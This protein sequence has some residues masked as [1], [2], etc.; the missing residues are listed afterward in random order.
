M[1]RFD[2]HPR[3]LS[4]L[5][6]KIANRELA[7]PDFQRSF[8]WDPNQTEMLIESIASGFPA[9]S[10]LFAK[11][12]PDFLAIREFEGAPEL[13]DE[14]PNE[15]V[16][17]GQQRLTSL[18]QA[19]TGSGE[20]EYFVAIQHLLDGDVEAAV[21]HESRKRAERKRLGD[22]EVQARDLLLPIPRLFEDNG[23]G[24]WRDQVLA[25][26][27]DGEELGTRLWDVHSQWLSNIQT[28]QFPVVTLSE[29]T[30]LE[31]ICN[32]FE[33][34]NNT[35]VRL[36]VFELLTARF[37]PSGVDLRGRLEEARTDSGMIDEFS[38]DP[39]Y[40]LQVL[41][42]RSGKNS[43][44]R[45]SV[46]KLEPAEVREHWSAVVHGVDGALRFFRDHCGVVRSG[47][48][49][50]VP[51]LLPLA[52]IWPE[53][54]ASVPGPNQ[55][56]RRGRLST[57][58][59]R[60]VL[61]QQYEN[62]TNTKALKDYREL[63]VWLDGGAPPQSV[64]EFRF[65]Q[66]LRDV[67]HRQRAVYRGLVGLMATRGALDFHNA[68]RLTWEKV[69]NQEINDHHVFPQAWLRDELP[70]IPSRLRDTILNRALIDKITNIRIGRRAPSDYIEEMAEELGESLLSEIL[71]S[72]FLPSD[73]D[74][75]LRR[76]QFEDFL[77]QREKWL[78]KE[79]A[80]VTDVAIEHLTPN[81]SADA[82][83]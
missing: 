12:R 22:I 81:V 16:L 65:D 40:L 69:H 74:G 70:S 45:S 42:L 21:F 67:T 31:A 82:V 26:R 63:P 41:A 11:N 83:S 75:P 34:L 60:S 25:Q 37:W 2:T 30:S 76:D 55:A 4:Y 54:V 47:W 13:G 3:D 73:L 62:A 6:Q 32:I 7:L 38:L 56:T 53:H 19:L 15:I 5:L 49:P 61:G 18:Y 52:A 39:Y 9:G 57:W 66:R 58:Y 23:F 10:L 20:Y 71:G 59:W 50:Y 36:S 1:G 79:I 78:L 28:Y 77:D 27:D 46:L 72:H 64:A 44:T 68:Q 33:T 35:G 48:L 80:T 14:K 8:V 29:D 24:K 17:D 51:M 43:C